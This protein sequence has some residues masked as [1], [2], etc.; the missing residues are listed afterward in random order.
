MISHYSFEQICKKTFERVSRRKPK[1]YSLVDEY[2]EELQKKLKKS[3]HIYVRIIWA[4]DCENPASI[5]NDL[6]FIALTEN[7]TNYCVFYSNEDIVIVATYKTK[8]IKH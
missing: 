8:R 4:E 1:T 5:A 3:E 7:V 6:L 2:V